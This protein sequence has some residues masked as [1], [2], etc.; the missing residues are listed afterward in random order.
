MLIPPVD[1]MVCGFS[2]KSVSAENSS[3]GDHHSCIPEGSGQT[4]QTFQALCR[5]L[6]RHLPRFV[7]CENVGGLLKSI[8][9][10][11]PQITAVSREHH[12][13]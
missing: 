10:R 2:C 13:F 5:Y 3:R 12:M 4:G 8:G 6:H 9:G 11:P 1:F 7:L